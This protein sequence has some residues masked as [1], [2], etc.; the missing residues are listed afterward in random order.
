MRLSAGGKRHASGAQYAADSSATDAKKAK[1]LPS[2]IFSAA[3]KPTDE[4]PLPWELVIYCVLLLLQVK[5]QSQQVVRHPTVPAP[6]AAPRAALV[7][8]DANSSAD[9]PIHPPQPPVW[10]SV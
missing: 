5:S 6:G 2:D 3:M 7:R 8:G 9:P 10:Q 1:V 4:E